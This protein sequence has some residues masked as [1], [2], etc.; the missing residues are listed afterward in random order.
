[1]K[2]LFATV[3]DVVG[4]KLIFDASGRSTG[5]ATVKYSHLED[6]EKAIAKYNTIELD[7]KKRKKVW[8]KTMR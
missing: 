1:M 8:T 4:A 5:V 6:A 7:G 3:G 2:E